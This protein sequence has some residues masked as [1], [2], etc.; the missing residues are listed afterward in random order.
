MK[1]LRQVKSLILLSL[2]TPYSLF[3]KDAREAVLP[4]KNSEGTESTHA[5]MQS[6]LRPSQPY[7]SASAT[8]TPGTN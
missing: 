4:T 1:N 6:N 3:V 8:A 7:V 2:S 5:H